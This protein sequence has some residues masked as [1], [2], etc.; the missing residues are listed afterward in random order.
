MSDILNFQNLKMNILKI[1]QKFKSLMLSVY[2]VS[3]ET[4]LNFRSFPMHC[5]SE[6]IKPMHCDSEM[7]NLVVSEP[8]LL[9]LVFSY[10]YIPKNLR[11]EILKNHR[12]KTLDIQFPYMK[13]HWS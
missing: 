7:V 5:D 8:W 11:K 10:D 3:K 2:N 13:N 6:T 12:E 4:L 9:S 1:F